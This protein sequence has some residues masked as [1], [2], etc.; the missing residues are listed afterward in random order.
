[1]YI[2]SCVCYKM[3]EKSGTFCSIVWTFQLNANTEAD[4]HE[5]NESTNNENNKRLQLRHK[6]MELQ[7]KSIFYATSVV[8]HNIKSNDDYCFF[9]FL[10]SL[11]LFRYYYCCHH[12]FRIFHVLFPEYWNNGEE[13]GSN[14]LKRIVVMQKNIAII[15]IVHKFRSLSHSLVLARSSVCQ[16]TLEHRYNC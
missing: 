6:K 3:M 9:H 4:L 12:K 7:K 11:F 15:S 8:P 1:M 10:F 13:S 14:R 16:N 2:I 5:T